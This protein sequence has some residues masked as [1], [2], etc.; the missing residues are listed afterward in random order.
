MFHKTWNQ[1]TPAAGKCQENDTV[2]NIR[3]TAFPSNA[4]TI[5]IN[6]TQY[7]AG[8]FPGGGVTVSTNASG[9]PAPAIL[10]DPVDGADCAA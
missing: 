10:V 1:I 3:I 8:N 2:S 5:T 7:T 4:T 9:N 6:G